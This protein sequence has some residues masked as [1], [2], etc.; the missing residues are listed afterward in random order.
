MADRADR[1][2]SFG[3]V[4]DEYDRGRPGYPLAAVRW[5]LGDAPLDVVDLGAGT[6]KLT[7]TLVTAGHRVLA[8]EPSPEMRAHLEER[9]PGVRVVAAA[10]EATGLA[11][12]SC[13]AV[14]AGAAFHWFDRSR[15]FPEIVR[16]LRG[17]GVLGLL[18]NGFDRTVPWID[19]FAQVSGSQ[20]YGN[21][22]HWPDPEELSRY[23]TE[24]EDADFPHGHPVDRGRLRD[25]TTSRSQVA[26]LAP[27]E[28]A[29]LLT[30]V[31]AL[32]ES[33][34]E[35]TGRQCVD[36]SYVTRTRRAAGLR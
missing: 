35:L 36:M 20:G 2:R 11:P 12:A 23:F 6:G 34:P 1:A 17:P 10:A 13:D 32:W 31:D 22:G 26:T 28:R 15:A 16:I 21:Q 33:E 19:H 27:D 9:L 25:L 8:V 18:G 7:E 3:S 30:R 5:L 24:V 14:V 4:A 29:T